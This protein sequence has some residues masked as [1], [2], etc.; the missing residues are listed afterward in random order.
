MT[1]V[2]LG[3]ADLGE[4]ELRDAAAGDLRVCV[5]R[6]G[7]RWFA[8]ETWCSHE[9]CPLSDGWLE[10]EAVR[11]ACHGALFALADGVPLEGPANDPIRVFPAREAG[12]RLEAD[13]PMLPA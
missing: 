8:F 7:G 11:C 5:A 9:E 13:L 3:P 6:R 4:G 10:D 2:D 12:G 1:W